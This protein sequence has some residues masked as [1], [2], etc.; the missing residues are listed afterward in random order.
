MLSDRGHNTESKSAKRGEK[1]PP[2]EWAGPGR[3]R[4]YSIPAEQSSLGVFSKILNVWYEI[5][6]EATGFVCAC[7]DRQGRSGICRHAC[8]PGPHVALCQEHKV[9]NETQP[10]PEVAASQQ[11]VHIKGVHKIRYMPQIFQGVLFVQKVIQE[12]RVVGE[13]A[14]SPVQGRRGP[15]RCGHNPRSRI[16]RA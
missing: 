12:S 10:C 14:T 9:S 3:R 11:G 4:G 1:R 8:S 5:I 13:D 7:N 2:G 16:T 6:L 15:T